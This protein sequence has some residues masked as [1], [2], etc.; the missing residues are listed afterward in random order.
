MSLKQDEY[1]LKDYYKRCMDLDREQRRQ[2]AEE[3][4]IPVTQAAKAYYQ[5]QDLV[6]NDFINIKKDK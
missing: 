5:G 6:M 2:I 3:Y 1:T 4:G